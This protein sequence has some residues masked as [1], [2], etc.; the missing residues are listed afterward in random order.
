[1]KYLVLFFAIFLAIHL[2]ATPKLISMTY[3]GGANSGGTLIQ[4]T[5][6][7]SGLSSYYSLH[8]TGQAGNS[9]NADPYGSV[10][11]A[12]NGNIY[13][14]TYQ[15]GTNHKGTIFQYNCS[16]NTY[17]VE[18][19]FDS[20]S[21]YGPLGSLLE[22]SNGL[23]YGLTSRGGAFGG[24][25]I[26]SYAIGGN[27]VT[28]LA[29]LPANAHPYGSLIQA[30]DGN[31][32]GM[33]KY[34]GGNSSGTIFEFNLSNNTYTVKY[35]LLA[36]AQ[37]SGSLLEVGADTL[38]G[39]TFGD[40]TNMMGSIF[41]YIPASNTYT[42]CYNFSMSTGG[43][44]CS[45]LTLAG[46]GLLYGTTAL[47]GVFHDGVLF[48]YDIT[49]QVYTDIHDFNGMDGRNPL[50]TV[51]QA[52]DG[53]LYG[54]TGS[55][56]TYSLGNIF[57]YNI[58]TA[59]LTSL[60]SFNGTDGASPQFGGMTEYITPPVVIVQP[61][62][63]STC[64][65]TNVTFIASATFTR[66]ARW[67][68]STNGGLSFVDL[69]NI[70]D[71]LSVLAA[72]ESNGYIYRAI[73]ADRMGAD[74]TANAILTVYKPATRTINTAVCHGDSYTIGV[75][76]YTTEGIYNDTLP[77]ASVSGCDSIVT[78]NLTV[79]QPAIN[80][81]RTSACQ[82]YTV[83]GNTYTSTGTYTLNMPGASI[84]GCDSTIIVDVV[85]SQNTASTITTT[86]CQSYTVGSNTYTSSGTYTTTLSG[87]SV[88]GC[89]S[90]VTLH[91]SVYPVAHTTISSTVCQLEGYRLGNR[92]Y[93]SSGTY[94]DTIVGG[95]QQGCDSIVTLF[96][97]VRPLVYDSVHATICQSAGYTIGSHTYSE[98]GVYSDTISNAGPNGCDRV[99][100]LDLT[101]IKSINRYAEAIYDTCTAL[102]TGATYQWL[103]C[104]SGQ[105]IP[106][107]TA[108]SYIATSAGDYRCIV[109]VGTCEDTTDCVSVATTGI[110]EVQGSG[111]SLYP[112]PTSGIFMIEQNSTGTIHLEI[113]NM[114]G[115][116]LKEYAMSGNKSQVD[117]SDLSAGV[118]QVQISDEKQ[119]QKTLKI[120]KE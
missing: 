4:Y 33:T 64:P 90:V 62:S 34:D 9:G 113:I 89:D 8:G 5:A 37:P 103:A 70:S 105:V 120:T 28:K 117:I 11:Q 42:V 55:G 83:A 100:V 104:S 87:A 58:G 78:L 41:R 97:T 29:D 22:V 118:Y 27:T 2:Q 108:R 73:F 115:S 101:A 15:D 51:Y 56:G 68:V 23:L 13:G 60:F 86:A 26:F 47:G 99:I 54:M 49:N 94:S 109:S 17:T 93:T 98:T 35:S 88:T 57:S 71:T 110:N 66:S 45:S 19:S 106:G 77:N 92:V 7:N 40:G 32:Y 72:V 63:Q 46:N 16:T 114:L 53:L 91:L 20:I 96:L 80:L 18:V 119:M 6:G 67:Q 36:G 107:A 38:Y 10:I 24:G 44:P 76:I 65:G 14:M 31:L 112:N 79:Y 116:R 95:G 52:S 84:A 43:S 25:T 21:G 85:I 61:E 81:I 82:S 39:L 12:S 30:S 1:M 59:S 102:Q 69:P 3:N 48:S 75:N 111:I 50:C 74:T